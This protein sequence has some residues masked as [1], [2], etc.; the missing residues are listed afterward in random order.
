MPYRRVLVDRTQN[1]HKAPDY[2]RLNPNGLIPVLTDGELVL[3]ECAAIVLHLADTHPQAHLAPPLG[4]PQR[5]EFYKWLM[6]LTNSLQATLIVYF[7]P[8]RWVDEGNAAGVAQVKAHAQEKVLAL[9]QQ[10]EAHQRAAD[11]TAIAD[12]RNDHF[13]EGQHADQVTVLHHDERTDVLVGHG[14][15]HHRGAIEVG[16]HAVLTESLQREAAQT[17][18]HALVE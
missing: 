15:R 6:W 2:L 12:D 16:L 13:P 8:E 14:V 18:V 3:Y 17:G 7:Y 5:A 10:L 4:T 1:R 11:L 9:L